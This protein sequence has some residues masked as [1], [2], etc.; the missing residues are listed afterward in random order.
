MTRGA[1]NAAAILAAFLL[2]LA[3]LGSQHATAF[4]ASAA[5]LVLLIATVHYARVVLLV[6]PAGAAQATVA[7]WSSTRDAAFQPQRD[8]DAAGKPRPRAPGAN[9]QTV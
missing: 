2:F 8:P 3:P 9:L 7:A 5:A 1:A 4:T 6:G